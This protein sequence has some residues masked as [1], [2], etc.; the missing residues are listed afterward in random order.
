MAFFGTFT[1][2]LQSNRSNK[3]LLSLK[4]ILN[5][6]NAFGTAVSDEFGSS[7]AISETYIV[8]SAAA[9][10]DAGGTS[11]GKVYIFS[12]TTGNLLYTLDNPNAYST[13]AGDLFGSPSSSTA[14]PGIA[15]FG[16]YV[17]IGAYA[18]DDATASF[19]GKAYI[20]NI[21][22]FPPAPAIISSATYTLN[23]P[24]AGGGTNADQFGAAVGVFDVIAVVGAPGEKEVADANAN[25]NSG[26]VYVYNVTTGTLTHTLSNPVGADGT[27]PGDNFGISVAISETYI[28][29]GAPTVTL[30]ESPFTFLNSGKVYVFNVTTGALLRTI[31]NPNAFDTATGDL[32]GSSIA[33]S[34]NYIIASAWAE[35]SPGGTTSG[36]VY[37]FSA[38]TGALLRTINNPNAFGT[39]AGDQFGSSVSALGNYAIIG[40]PGEDDAGGTTSGKSYVFDITTGVMVYTVNNPNTFTTSS[41]DQFGNSVAISGSYAVVGAR[42]EDDSGGLNSGVAYVYRIG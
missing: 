23:N 22:S 17:I 13:S 33:V 4:Y 36:V 41:A 39:T 35:D 18:E 12:T 40:A 3:G 10:D 9:E 8:V 15:I 28:V 24:N 32:F 30:I 31:I 19:S 5:N 25:G 20:Y 14:G 11:S 26:K 21:A 27:A 29:V 7:V 6:P 42:T 2:G 37:V 38:S 34:G 1:A 16:N